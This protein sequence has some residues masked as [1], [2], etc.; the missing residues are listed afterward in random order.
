MIIFITE[1]IVI[2]LFIFFTYLFVKVIL[3]RT[4]YVQVIPRKIIVVLIQR[5]PIIVKFIQ[6]PLAQYRILTIRP[7]AV[8]MRKRRPLIRRYISIISHHQIIVLVALIQNI[9]S[10]LIRGRRSVLC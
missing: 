6:P 4:R 2:I 8:D 1:A 3:L 7:P 9:I 10:L 5:V